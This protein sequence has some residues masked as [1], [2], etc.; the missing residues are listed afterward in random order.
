MTSYTCDPNLEINGHS[1]HAMLESI[2]RDN[3]L[4][5]LEKHGLA[6]IDEDNWYPLQDLLDVMNDMARTGGAMM[7]FVSIG[8]AAGANSTLSSAAQD[9][10]L[11]EFLLAYEQ[12]YQQLYR[13]GDPGEIQ[14]E[15]NAD[16]HLIITLLDFPFPD[17]LMYGLLYSYAKRFSH[18][19]MRFSV[20]Y[21]GEHLR[22]DEGGDRTIIHVTWS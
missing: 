4:H 7:D 11:K 10:S 18:A 20:A 9:L 5:I 2:N 6:D 13:N 22:R 15:S 19:G 21:D 8:M 17:D 1:A 12:H 3:Y 16:N 14:V